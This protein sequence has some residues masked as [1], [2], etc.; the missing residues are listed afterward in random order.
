MASSNIRVSELASLKR[1]L[2][3]SISSPNWSSLLPQPPSALLHLPQ[4]PGH[5]VCLPPVLPHELTSSPVHRP[6]KTSSALFL[7]FNTWHFTTVPANSLNYLPV[8][9]HTVKLSI[10]GKNG[11]IGGKIKGIIF[12]NREQNP[13]VY[14]QR[15]KGPAIPKHRLPS[16]YT[17]VE[18]PSGTLQS[19]N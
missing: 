2:T 13:F 10:G 5:L 15:F 8:Q 6:E 16:N 17:I 7:H 18:T 12:R 19:I 4:Q 14:V 3:S 1:P 9:Y 11:E